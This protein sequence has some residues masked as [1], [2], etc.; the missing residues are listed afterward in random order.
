MVKRIGVLTSG[1]DSPG[2]NACVK[3]VVETGLQLG[4]EVYGIYRGYQGLIENDIKR[5][6]EQDVKYVLNFGGSFL[7]SARSAEFTTPAGRKKAIANINKN[8]LSGV[9]CIGG[10]G[11]FRGANELMQMGATVIAI[12]ATVDND[13]YS[14]ERSIGFDTAVNNAVNMIDNIKQ[15]MSSNGRIA[16]IE[17]MGR[18]GGDIALHSALASDADMVVIPEEPIKREEIIKRVKLLIKQG[19]NAPSIIVAEKQHDLDALVKELEKA[20]GKTARGIVLGY[21]QRGGSPTSSD[22][23]LSIRYGV[24]AVHLL[25]NESGSCALCLNHD[26]LST[27]EI[28]KAVEETSHFRSDIYA[29]FRLLHD[30]V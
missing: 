25:A 2:M 12:P 30:P 22:R 28:A 14:S 20:T 3:A 23:M 13:V 11:T 1:G 6:T 19:V 8:K 21:M 27:M 26:M 16:V 5:L 29:L 10:N 17:V 9:I 15:T 24:Q 7:Q 18:H 4:I